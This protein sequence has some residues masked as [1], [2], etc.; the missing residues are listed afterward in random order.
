MTQTSGLEA[1]QE[2]RLQPGGTDRDRGTADAVGRLRDAPEQ[3]SVDRPPESGGGG[4]PADRDDEPAGAVHLSARRGGRRA[5]PAAGDHHLLVLE[6][7]LDVRT[8]ALRVRKDRPRGRSEEAGGH[9][10]ACGQ[11][12][13][14]GR[15]AE[16]AAEEVGG[17]FVGRGRDHRLV[18]CRAVGCGRWRSRRTRSRNRMRRE[19]TAPARWAEH[20][21]RAPARRSA[22]VERDEAC[23]KSRCT[24]GRGTDDRRGHR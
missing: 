16:T 4:Q 3:P 7:H 20:L 24:E 2:L 6:Q 14:P 17:G 23:A 15:E 5:V 13:G 1:L 9:R 11:R 22:N 10:P 12:T 19:R 18:G 21:G 8:A